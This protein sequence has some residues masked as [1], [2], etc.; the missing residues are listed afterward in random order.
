[1]TNTPTNWIKNVTLN[2]NDL[3]SGKAYIITN[4]TKMTMVDKFLA[5]SNSVMPSIATIMLLMIFA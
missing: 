1:M 5:H 3:K 4:T 2:H